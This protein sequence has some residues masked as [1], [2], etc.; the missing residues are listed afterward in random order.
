MKKL[1]CL[2]L[3]ICLLGLAGCAG[4]QPTTDPFTPGFEGEIDVIDT[5]TT[6][7]AD[8]GDSCV[9]QVLADF[10]QEPGDVRYEGEASE[11]QVDIGFTAG[12]NWKSFTFSQLVWETETYSVDQELFSGTMQA[13][14]LF[15][16]RITFWGDMTTYGISITDENDQVRHYA[17]YTS[18]MD[19][20]LVLEEFWPQ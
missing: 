18:G 14:Q 12:V 5:P 10:T 2:T 17:V 4:T 15:V 1:I 9:I 11:Y 3:A 13:G 20:S 7:L 8:D 16:A 19:G 6:T